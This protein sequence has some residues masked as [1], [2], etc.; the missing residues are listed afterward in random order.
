MTYHLTSLL[1][2][3]VM[4][5]SI[6][7]LLRRAHLHG[8]H[9]LWWITLAIAII[10]LGSW[11]R[12]TDLVARYLGVSYPPI[13]AVLIAFALVLVKMLTMDLERSRLEQRLRRLAQR[14]A[15]LEARLDALTPA[16]YSS[17]DHP[18]ANLLTEPPRDGLLSSRDQSRGE[19]PA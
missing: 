18:Q 14:L 6:L 9:A 12:L 15:L 7:W 8:A 17:L 11:P 2:G 10:L 16:A 3:L 19:R 5:G 4:A 1:I 13:I